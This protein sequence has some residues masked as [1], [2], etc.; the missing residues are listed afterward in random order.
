MEGDSK[1]IERSGSERTIYSASAEAYFCDRCSE[2]RA[3]SFKSTARHHGTCE[4]QNHNEY[5]CIDGYGTDARWQRKNQRPVRSNYR[6][7]CRQR[8]MIKVAKNLGKS[9]LFKQRANLKLLK[10][11]QKRSTVQKKS[12]ATYV[13][14]DFLCKL[15]C[16]PAIISAWRTGEHDGR[17]SDRTSYAPSCEDHESGNQPSSDRCAVRGWPCTE[18]GRYRD[19]SHRP[20]R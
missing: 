10:K 3:D 6:K 11:L 19:G 12:P 5:L 16:F 18:R 14:E 8:R 1:S 13:T 4:F 7:S 17:P 9:K 15:L 2:Q 20:G